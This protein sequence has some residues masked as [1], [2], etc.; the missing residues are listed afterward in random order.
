VIIAASQSGAA[1]LGESA[2]IL[3]GLIIYMIPAIV[4]ITRKVPNIGAV[5]MIDVFLGW[6]L[7]GW[8]AALAMSCLPRRRP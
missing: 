1:A 2:F 5:V 4:A 8:V 3:L 6:T 7:V